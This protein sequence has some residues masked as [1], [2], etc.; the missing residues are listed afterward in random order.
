MSLPELQSGPRGVENCTETRSGEDSLS[1]SCA[2]A[3][4]KDTKAP[5]TVPKRKAAALEPIGSPIAE[6]A[7]VA[8]A[9]QTV[10]VSRL[11]SQRPGPKAPRASNYQRDVRRV[12]S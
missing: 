12:A 10:S 2:E 1:L 6:S 3:G 9:A 7:E 8:D 11:L 5:K 4:S